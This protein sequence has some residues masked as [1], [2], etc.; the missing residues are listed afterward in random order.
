[1]TL[2]EEVLIKKLLTLTLTMGILFS[3]QKSDVFVI[4]EKEVQVNTRVNHQHYPMNK[5]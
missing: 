1:M 5:I 3:E 2:T 4:N